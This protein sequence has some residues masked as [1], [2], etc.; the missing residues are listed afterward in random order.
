MYSPSMFCHSIF[1]DTDIK[2]EPFSFNPP[3]NTSN[4]CCNDEGSTVSEPNLIIDENIPNTKKSKQQ[5]CKICGKTLSSASS[6]YV[7]LKQH[8][9]NKPYRCSVC[10]AAFCRKPYLEVHM[11][12]HTGEKP[13]ECDICKKRFTQKS[14]LNTHKRSHSGLRPFAC[15]VCLKRFSVKS[16]LVAHQWSH[17]AAGG[18]LCN[19]CHMSFN[20]KGQFM[21][22]MRAHNNKLFTCKDCQKCFSKESYLIR[23]RNRL[24]KTV[25]AGSKV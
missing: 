13:F 17:A 2:T 7:H 21:Q 19:I 22:H 12:V 20:N 14:S 16:Y 23:H 18:L 10:D 1:N 9:N 25:E 6:Y 3:T 24:H 11:R 8:S 4:E 5:E 15:D